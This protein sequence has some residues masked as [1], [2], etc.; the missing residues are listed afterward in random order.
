MIENIDETTQKQ[1]E[2]GRINDFFSKTKSVYLGL[3]F[4]ILIASLLIAPYTTRTAIGLWILATVL[5][6]IPRSI[7]TLRYFR[8]KKENHLTPDNIAKWEDQFY[9]ASI[10]PFIAFSSIAFMPFAGN[11]HAGFAIAAL[12]LVALLT[13][14]VMIYSASLKVVTLYLYVSLGCLIVRCL[15]EG[16]YNFYVFA[17]Y[18]IALLLILRQLI[19]IQYKN[20]IDHL[21]TRLHFEKESLTDPLTGIANRRH[22]EI[23]LKS[24]VPISRRTKNEF[25]VVMMDIDHFKKYNDTHGHLKGD[26]LLIKLARLVEKQIRSSDFFARYGGEEFA[27][28]L[29]ANSPDT[30]LELVNKLMSDIKSE[31]EITMSAGLSSSDMADSFDQ[32]LELADKALY[33]S[34]QQGR[35]QATLAQQ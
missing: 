22:L 29:T 21:V 35:N 14:G 17:V 24:F 5:T 31:L 6:Y 10:L 30:A 4:N 8:A 27:L 20:F 13:G 26:E 1:L 28:V 9:L 33:Q 18:F 34:K 32:L 11:V 16:T 23:F 2:F 15:Y 25:Q 19:K 3:T 12:A 7:I